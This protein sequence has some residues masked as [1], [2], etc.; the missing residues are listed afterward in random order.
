MSLN[1]LVEVGV[2]VMCSGAGCP[3][4]DSVVSGKG[5]SALDMAP[6][7]TVALISQEV[8]LPP[9]SLNIFHTIWLWF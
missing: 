3:G 9:W 1:L 8:G 5:F 6:N 2:T 7:V 4:L